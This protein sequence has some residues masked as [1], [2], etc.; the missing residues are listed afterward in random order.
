MKGLLR[1]IEYRKDPFLLAR[2]V[3]HNCW[4]FWFEGRTA[5]AT[6][7]NVG[8][9]APL[10]LFSISGARSSIRRERNTWIL[11]ISVVAFILPHLVIIAVARYCA[12]VLPLMCILAAGNL[13]S[14]I[15]QQISSR[16]RFADTN[17]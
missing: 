5:K 13:F 12:T 1:G 14:P 11:V 8:I 10:I 6:I 9:L 4:A 2:T 16:F 17:V 15:V 3:V 7:I